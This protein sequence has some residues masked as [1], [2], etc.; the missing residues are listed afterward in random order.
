MQG[1]LLAGFTAG[2]ELAFERVEQS[3]QRHAIGGIGHECLFDL[4][5]GEG[6]AGD[7]AL[8]GSLLGG[9]GTGLCTGSRRPT[10]LGT[11][12]RGSTSPGRSD[13]ARRLRVGLLP[14]AAG[15]VA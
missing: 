11:S 12:S 13:V 6:L 8:A 9:R 5:P 10:D 15:Q 7:A 2:E 1:P 3:V 14:G 4:R